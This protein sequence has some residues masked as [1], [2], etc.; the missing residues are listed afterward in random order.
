MQLSISQ[1]RGCRI[2]RTLF[3]SFQSVKERVLVK[4]GIFGMHTSGASFRGVWKVGRIVAVELPFSRDTG[5]VS[6]FLHE[7]TECFFGGTK[8]TKV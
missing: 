3:L 7:V 4:A 1:K 6:G 2:A 5:L 8:A